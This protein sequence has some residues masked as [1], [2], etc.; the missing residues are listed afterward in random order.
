MGGKKTTGKAGVAKEQFILLSS[1]NNYLKY[2]ISKPKF[3]NNKELK[4]P[5]FFQSPKLEISF[6]SQTTVLA[7][8]Q[9]HSILKYMQ[10]CNKTTF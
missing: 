3:L 4:K 5:E 8:Q 9:K 1:N 10:G 2:I 6:Q 7:T